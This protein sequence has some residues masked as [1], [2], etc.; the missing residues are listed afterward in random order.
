NITKDPFSLHVVKTIKDFADKI[1]IVTVAEFVSD[2]EIQKTI[3]SLDIDYTQG[4]FIAEPKPAS[5]LEK[6]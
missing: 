5:Q 2:E 1:G 4:Y 6:A 3:Q